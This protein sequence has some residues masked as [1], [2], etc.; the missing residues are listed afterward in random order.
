MKDYIGIY[1]VNNK[2]YAD[3]VEA[4]LEAQKTNA[5]ISWDFHQARFN[6][7][8]WTKEPKSSLRELYKIRAQQIRDEYDYIIIMF[9]GGADSTNV[10]HS[11]LSN[12]IPVDE[13]VSSIPLSGLKNYKA[14]YDTNASNHASEWLLTT[15]PYLQKVFQTHPNIKITIN[16]FFENLLE[17]KT[18]E[19]IY[20]ASDWVH[21]TTTARYDF[22]K[23]THIRQL[24]DQ[25]K[26][27]AIVYGCE[28]PQIMFHDG[29]IL[30]AIMDLGVNVPR[31]PFSDFYSNIDITLFYS[32]PKM[33]H[34]LCK[35]SHEIA[36]AI[37]NLPQ[38]KYIQDLIYN[39]S[40]EPE[41]RISYN[42]STCQRAIVPIIYPDI[43]YNAFQTDKSMDIFMAKHDDWFHNNHSNLKISQQFDSDFKLFI[44]DIKS[45]YLRDPRIGGQR[46]GFKAYGNFYTIGTK[47]KFQN[48]F[49]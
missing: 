18:D 14:N 9:T 29:K 21:P 2:V 30:N 38:F 24:A 10:L 36:K 16:D 20:T 31:Q 49:E 13:I 48:M 8:D 5:E 35:Q 15:T 6:K 19:W 39:T 23:L 45:E 25:G 41:K 43:N 40:W 1:S 26:K 27:I 3:K 37:F 11:F 44:K 4:I 33:P 42:N 7:L 32:T 47:E 34:I 12:N 46:R 28:K 17:L 22:S